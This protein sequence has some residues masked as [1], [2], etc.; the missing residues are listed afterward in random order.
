MPILFFIVALLYS[1]VGFGG[2]SS[3][4]AFL[5]LLE[6]PY[7]AI[8]PVALIC[9]IVVV[10]G[11]SWLFIQR[12]HFQKDLFW[13]LA[14]GSIPMAFLGGCIPLSRE[15]FLLLLGLV[16]LIAGLRLLWVHKK[17]AYEDARPMPRAWGVMTGAVLGLLAGLV[18]IGGGIF[19]AP[20]MLNLRWGQPRQVAAVC[21]V[22]I[23]LNS[24]AGLA[25]QLLKQGINASALDYWPLFIAVL[26]GGQIGSRLGSEKIPQAWIRTLTALLV[27]FVGARVLLRWFMG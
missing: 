3:Y 10:S 6:I 23:L 1:M 2:G 7:E 17:G 20:L 18:G 11:G 14:V 4:I 9:N 19:L 21:S 5:V 27:I 13:P 8:P 16:L 26:A 12:G 22:F 25:G 15:A 24:T